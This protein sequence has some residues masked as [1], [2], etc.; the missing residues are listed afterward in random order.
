MRTITYAIVIDYISPP[1]GGKLVDV[2]YHMEGEDLRVRDG[3]A[4]D[5]LRLVSDITRADGSYDLDKVALEVREQIGETM[6][7]EVEE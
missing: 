5:R 1:F 2:R 3:F 4:E 6:E 7:V